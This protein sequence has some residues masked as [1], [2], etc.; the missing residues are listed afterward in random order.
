MPF[1]AA[2]FLT[3]LTQRTGIYQMFDEKGVLIYV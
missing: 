1:D 3:N 2:S